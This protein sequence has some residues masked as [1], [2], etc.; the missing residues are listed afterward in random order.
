MFGTEDPGSRSTSDTDATRGRNKCQIPDRRLYRVLS[1]AH[2]GDRTQ[3]PMASYPMLHMPPGRKSVFRAGFGTDS[4]LESLKIGS[5]PALGR[6]EG[7]FLSFQTSLEGAEAL[8]GSGPRP[9]FQRCPYH[10]TAYHPRASEQ[11]AKYR[12]HRMVRAPFHKH[13]LVPN[14]RDP[15]ALYWHVYNLI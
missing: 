7:R 2:V 11:K 12:T 6:P 15:Q 9:T 10:S 14:P 8:S 3:C 4:N 13:R 5:R 1:V